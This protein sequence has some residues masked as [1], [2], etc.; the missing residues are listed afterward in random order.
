MVFVDIL[1]AS[2][3]T[4]IASLWR[5]SY[6][7]IM[8]KGAVYVGVTSK[9]VTVKSL[10]TFN[11]DRYAA[12]KWGDDNGI[13]WDILGQVGTL[14]KQENSPILYGED[15]SGDVNSYLFG[16]SQSGWYVNTFANNFGLAN[17]VAEDAADLET[18]ED[19]R[20]A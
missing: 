1:N 17:F 5:Q 15:Y 20:T 12:L 4:D 18:Y 7:Y 19:I 11:Q 3:K 2:S 16:S 9:D 13:F 6:D 14:L 10:K 8:E